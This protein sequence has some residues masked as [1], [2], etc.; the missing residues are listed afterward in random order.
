MHDLIGSEQVDL[1][2]EQCI[3]AGPAFQFLSMT[4]YLQCVDIV[5]DNVDA[6]TV[7]GGLTTQS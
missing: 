2:D 1:I 4:G 7:P 5:V 3:C 6:I